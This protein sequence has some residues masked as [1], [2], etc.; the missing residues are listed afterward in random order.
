MTITVKILNYVEPR[1]Q[2]DN[3]YWKITE[4]HRGVI[5][6]MGILSQD[7]WV[8]NTASD[9]INHALRTK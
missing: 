9:D 1:R 8:T 5:L 2:R 4:T 3:E 6:D 7:K